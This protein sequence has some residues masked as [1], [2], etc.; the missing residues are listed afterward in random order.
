MARGGRGGARVRRQQWKEHVPRRPQVGGGSVLHWGCMGDGWGARPKWS[1]HSQRPGGGAGTPKR[2]TACGCDC[3]AAQSGER[4][5]ACSLPDPDRALALRHD[6]SEQAAQ[7]SPVQS[8]LTPSPMWRWAAHVPAVRQHMPS[9]L[10]HL[11]SPA[12]SGWQR[13]SANGGLTCSCMQWRRP[14]ASTCT[15]CCDQLAPSWRGRPTFSESA[16]RSDAMERSPA[17]TAMGR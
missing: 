12:P 17:G 6:A 5:V 3:S 13:V 1:C 14:I 10:A 4:E 15:V 11:A 2:T 7:H 16:S 9:A 8:S